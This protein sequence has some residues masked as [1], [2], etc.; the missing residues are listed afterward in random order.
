M[1]LNHLHSTKFKFAK[2]IAKT[3]ICA[4]NLTKK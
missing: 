1:T 4:Q 3:Q 2:K